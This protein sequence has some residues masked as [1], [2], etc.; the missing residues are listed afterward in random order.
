MPVLDE[1]FKLPSTIFASAANLLVRHPKQRN[2]R[3]KIF[4]LA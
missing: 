1:K 2:R 3:P 4:R